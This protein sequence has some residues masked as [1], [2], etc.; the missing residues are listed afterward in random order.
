[1]APLNLSKEKFNKKANVV[2]SDQGIFNPKYSTVKT[3]AGADE[4][5]GIK[6]VY[7][8]FGVGVLV[9]TAAKDWGFM[10]RSAAFLGSANIAVN[11]IK[12]EGTISLGRDNDKLKGNATASFSVTAATLSQ[13]IAVAKKGDTSAMASAFASIQF[14]ATADGIDNYDSV[15]NGGWGS[16]RIEGNAK[17]SVTAIAIATAQAFAAT[18]E[19]PMSKDMTAFARAVA[20]SLAEAEILTKG[21]NNKKGVINTGADE[22]IISAT[23]TSN[24]A[25]SATA[26]ANVFSKSSPGNQAVADAIAFAFA[27]ADDTAIAIDNTYGKILTGDENDKIEAHA[28]ADGKAIAI[29]NTGGRILTGDDDDTIIAKAAGGL[30]AYGIFGGNIKTEDGNDTLIASN[31]GGGVKIRM[32]DGN[33]F[34]E[35]FGKATVYGGEDYDKLSLGSYNKSDFNIYNNNGFTVFELD[36]TTMRTRG[37]E[38]YIFADGTYNSGL[39]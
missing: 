10:A 20:I 32:G 24:S 9:R 22:D 4:I 7:G 21:I 17:G 19:N 39:A 31:F 12:N 15:I 35:G 11:G 33:D 18:M 8:D 26:I 37:F 36:G 5:T 16:D 27:K 28:K 6:S 38:S 30:E 23:S 25:T 34:V 1:M 3:L 14:K 2:Y 13:A 29:N